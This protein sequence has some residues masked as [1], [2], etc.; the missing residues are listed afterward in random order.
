MSES[1]TDKA[2]EDAMLY[3]TGFIKDG[4]RIAPE[5]AL[6]RD[7]EIERVARGICHHLGLDPE[8]PVSHAYGETMTP[9]EYEREVGGSIPMIALYSQRWMLYRRSAAHAL[10]IQAALDDPELQRVTE[11]R[12]VGEVDRK[13]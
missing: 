10:A 4:E 2:F 11:A 5:D 3:G 9:A 12:T 7:H 8:E 6:D 1:E 13:P